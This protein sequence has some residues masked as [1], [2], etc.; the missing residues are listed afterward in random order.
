VIEIFKAIVEFFID[1][2]Y[3]ILGAIAAVLGAGVLV[4]D[5]DEPS[6]YEEY[7]RIIRNNPARN[8][9]LETLNAVTDEDKYA[10]INE[11][12]IPIF[13][14]T[15]RE[16]EINPADLLESG[17]YGYQTG[18]LSVGL[19]LVSIPE[20]HLLGK[21]EK[22]KWYYFDKRMVAGEHIYVRHCVELTKNTY[23]DLLAAKTGKSGLLFVH[24]FNTD[25]LGGLR[26]AAQLVFDLNTE[27]SP[28]KGGVTKLPLTSFYFSWP[29][30][31]KMTQYIADQ[32]RVDKSEEKFIEFLQLLKSSKGIENITIIAHSMGNRLLTRVLY[33]ISIAKHEDSIPKL[34]Q[35]ILVAPDVDKEQYEVWENNIYSLCRG[36][37][38]YA[39]SNDLALKV[40]KSASQY[41]RLGDS[42]NPIPI[43]TNTDTIDVSSCG[44]DILGHTPHGSSKVLSDINELIRNN[45]PAQSRFW[46]TQKSVQHGDYWE[47]KE[48]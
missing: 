45:T 8:D 7:Q 4:A 38:V 11:T 33:N 29:S 22:P 41:Q 19:A 12:L 27:K 1:N 24:G 18:E 37:T 28:E 35:I 21:L 39:S 20:T 46:L 2:I 16:A 36:L 31:G 9:D 42:S 34:G 25:F 10:L 17:H 44:E 15:N 30:Q 3:L 14:G 48:R 13:Y 26:R 23:K 32:A 47:I 6:E 5:N 43:Y 40:S